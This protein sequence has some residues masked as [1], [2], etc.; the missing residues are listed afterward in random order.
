M[1]TSPSG[2]TFTFLFLTFFVAF[3]ISFNYVL[4]DRDCLLFS[5]FFLVCYSFTFTFSCT[6]IG[7]R[8]LTIHRQSFSMTQTPVACDIHQT[9]DTHLHF[10]AQ[11]TFNLE[12][13]LNNTRDFT[14][15]I[16]CPFVY[17]SMVTNSGLLKDYM[18]SRLSYPINGSKSDNASLISW[19]VNT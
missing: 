12:F 6:C 9:F 17:F 3:A 18:R 1:Y 14:D 2:S 4:S 8:A 16:I 7:T 13:G 15:I 19:Q 11:L 5:Y 10:R